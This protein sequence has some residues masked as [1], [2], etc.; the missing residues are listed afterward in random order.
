MQ[1][2]LRSIAVCAVLAS[3]NAAAWSQAEAPPSATL[4][5][6]HDTGAVANTGARDDVVISFP[7]HVTG[8]AWMRLEFESVELAGKLFAGSESVLRLTST[9][10][11]A[12]QE[13]NSLHVGQ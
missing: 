9:Y 12:V 13:M 3:L 1:V 5:Y 11:A 2:I 10:D 8:A 7:V 6:P 4:V